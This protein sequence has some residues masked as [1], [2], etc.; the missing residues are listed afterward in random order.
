MYF[1][2]YKNLI[3]I[4]ALAFASQ[5]TGHPAAVLTLLTRRRAI[6]PL[7]CEVLVLLGAVPKVVYRWAREAGGTA[8]GTEGTEPVSWAL[9]VF[10]PTPM[11]P[12]YCSSG[13]WMISKSPWRIHKQFPFYSIWLHP[14]TFWIHI[15]TYVYIYIHIYIYDYLCIYVTDFFPLTRIVQIPRSARIVLPRS[16]KPAR[17]ATESIG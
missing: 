1:S 16:C 5:E 3:Y 4:S 11:I 14:H 6:P 8:A 2:L 17:Q 9:M 10:P 7:K 12:W 15:Y 13:I